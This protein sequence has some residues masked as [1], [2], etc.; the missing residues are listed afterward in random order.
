MKKSSLLLILIFFLSPCIKAQDIGNAINAYTSNYPVEQAYL[1]L[2]NNLYSAGDTVWFKAYMLA[3]SLPSA[4]S[5]NLYI[6]WYDTSGKLLLHQVYPI[7][8]ATVNGQFSIPS[9]YA[10]SAIHLLAYT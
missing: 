4:L 3:N 6:D 5:A 10:G 7:Y 1:H 8:H 2:D 9:A